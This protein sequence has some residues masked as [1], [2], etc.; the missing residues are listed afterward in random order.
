MTEADVTTELQGKMGEV[1]RTRVACNKLRLLLLVLAGA[2]MSSAIVVLN[3]S[4]Q[5]RSSSGPTMPCGTWWR[6]RA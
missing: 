3:M 1:R 5:Q 6:S 4:L 2:S